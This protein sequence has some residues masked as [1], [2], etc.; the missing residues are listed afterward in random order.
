MRINRQSL[1]WAQA[2][3]RRS[4]Q[5]LMLTGSMKAADAKKAQQQKEF[6]QKVSELN[7]S[8]SSAN[9]TQK[10]KEVIIQEDPDY[11][12][13]AVKEKDVFKVMTK[14]MESYYQAVGNTVDNLTGME[15]QLKYMQD[16]YNQALADGDM[17]KAGVIKEWTEKQFQDMSWIS[18]ASLGIT[19]FRLDNAKRL[20]GEAYGKE[21]E[22][23]MADLSGK[24]E[25]MS[26]GLKGAKS[27][28]EALQM[29]AAAKEKFMG[30]AEEVAGRYEAYTGNN[31]SPYEYR[32][33]EDFEGIKWDSH[34]LYERG[35]L[36][37]AEDLLGTEY[38]KTLDIRIDTQTGNIMDRKA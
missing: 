27:V 22:N 13:F 20:Y 31:L 37:K 11:A 23:W 32:T 14:E 24:A 35:N 19:H 17:E 1:F 6:W 16:A 8:S 36:Q 12:E 25:E 38:A 9:T 34:F 26:E 29:I 18:G 21:V 4:G 15:E 28:D 5:S 10:K 3:N 7:R 30:L 33:A 2:M